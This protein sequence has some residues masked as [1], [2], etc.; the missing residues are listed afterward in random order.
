MP[1]RRSKRKADA[2]DDGNEDTAS[3]AAATAAGAGSGS[4]R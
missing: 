4:T 1:P 3:A 2:V